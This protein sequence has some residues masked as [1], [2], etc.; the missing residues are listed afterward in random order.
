MKAKRIG[1]IDDKYKYQ[2]EL[3]FGYGYVMMLDM[4]QFVIDHY[5]LGRTISLKV[6]LVAGQREKD[7]TCLL[8]FHRNRLYKCKVIQKER[9]V[10]SLKGESL[11]LDDEIEIV[12]FNQTNILGVASNYGDESHKTKIELMIDEIINDVVSKYYK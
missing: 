5:Y 2:F 9:G 8:K 3:P 1:Y 6:S 12:W 4:A 11:V 10:I 7:Y